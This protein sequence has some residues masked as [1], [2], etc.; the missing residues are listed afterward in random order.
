MPNSE[1]LREA[2]IEECSKAVFAWGQ[3]ENP[4]KGATWESVYPDVRDEVRK[5]V[6]VVIDKH[7][8]LL[9]QS[10]GGDGWREA[11]RGV[12]E[13]WAEYMK[14]EACDYVRLHEWL[15]HAHAALPAA[16]TPQ[17]KP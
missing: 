14:D 16:P 7:L 13:M 9:S 15:E 10:G 17:V 3:A 5:I 12:R 11:E 4:T 8:S 6:G 1:E 2:V